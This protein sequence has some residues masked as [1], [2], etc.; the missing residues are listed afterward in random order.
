MHHGD[1]QEP[2]FGLDIQVFMDVI[3]C[4]DAARRTSLALQIAR[5]LRQLLQGN[6]VRR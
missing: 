2:T 4:G 6:I 3:A 5:F 1:K